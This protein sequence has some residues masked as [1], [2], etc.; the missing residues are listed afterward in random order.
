[1]EPIQVIDKKFIPFITAE[2][3]DVR[4]K[5][6]AVQIS[7]DYEGKKPIFIAILNG[8]F[9]FASDLFKEFGFTV[10]HVIDAAE[11]VMRATT[12]TKE[13]RLYVNSGRN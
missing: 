6:M 8:S 9:M 13:R 1:M 5:E 12:E 7:K 2:E 4:I 11:N 3:I 10:Q